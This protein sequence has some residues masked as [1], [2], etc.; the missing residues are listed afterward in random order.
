MQKDFLGLLPCALKVPFEEKIN[1]FVEDSLKD[2]HFDYLVEAN[3]NKQLDYF[4]QISAID[5]IEDLPDIFMA[6]GFN[7]F[8]YKA[9]MERFKNTGCF[10]SIN[11]KEIND[12][13]ASLSILDPHDDYTITCFN[14]TVMLVDRSFYVDLPVP[15][16]WQDLLE[17]EFAG[18]VAIRGHANDDFCEGI[19]LNIFKDYGMSGIQKFGRS[20]KVGLHPAQMVKM[21]GRKREDAPAVSAIPYSFAKLVMDSERVTS[22]RVTIVWP[23]DGAIVNPVTTLVKKSSVSKLKAVLDFLAGADAGQIYGTAR[24]PSLHPLVHNDLPQGAAFK[25]LGWDFILENDLEELIDELNIVF[26]ASFQGAAV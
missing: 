14:P 3:A 5:D 4:D 11:H 16:S 23:K 7:G 22:K 24:F 2:I 8:Y 6:P 25:W 19:L 9:F 10:I 21:A 17:P 26:K 18:K 13:L 15:E 12:D 1:L 20:F